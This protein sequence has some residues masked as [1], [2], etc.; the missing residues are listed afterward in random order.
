MFW[1]ESQGNVSLCFSL[2]PTDSVADT[3]EKIILVNV[4]SAEE[5]PFQDEE[6]YDEDY[7][8]SMDPEEDGDET[9]EKPQ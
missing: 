8:P 6:I 4:D 7:T 5:E 3:K 1:G 2:L 9:D